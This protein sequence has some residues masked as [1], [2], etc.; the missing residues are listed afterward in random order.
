[1][2]SE[3]KLEH[4]SSYLPYGLNVQSK[5]TSYPRYT[6]IETLTCTILCHFEVKGLY[7]IKPILRPLSD[8][9]KEIDH[10]G[11]KFVPLIYIIK[12]ISLFDL[13]DCIFEYDEDYDEDGIYVNAVYEGR[14]IDSITFDGNMFRCMNNDGSFDFYNPQHL[15][16]DLLSELHFDWKYRLIDQGLAI[17]INTLNNQK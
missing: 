6:R 5:R 16:L 9:T 12:K 10:N 1:M 3:L 8:L 17:D 14:V 7:Q 2:K 15:A 13:S 4:L 11:E